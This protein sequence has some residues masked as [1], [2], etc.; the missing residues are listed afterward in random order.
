MKG[1][2]VDFSI[3]PSVAGIDVGHLNTK[4][5][6]SEA[7][8]FLKELPHG[9]TKKSQMPNLAVGFLPQLVN[10]ALRP[11]SLAGSTGD[12]LPVVSK[13]AVLVDVPEIHGLYD[14]R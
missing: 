2:W 14:W 8:L 1:G 3:R 10:L 13:L 9:L 5:L 6:I 7:G 12:L 4:L 11:F